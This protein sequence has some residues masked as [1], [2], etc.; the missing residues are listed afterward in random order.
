MSRGRRLTPLFEAMRET[1]PAKAS[2]APDS[3]PVEVPVP[4]PAPKSTPASPRVLNG[5]R[6]LRPV[7]DDDAADSSPST[8][9]ARESLAASVKQ[10]IERTYIVPGRMLL[11]GVSVLV[12]V[13]GLTWIIA[14]T[15]GERRQKAQLLQ[16]VAES[17]GAPPLQPAEDVDPRPQP[18]PAAPRT[19]PRA[20][21]T[22]SVQPITPESPSP[23]PDP[24]VNGNNYLYVVTTS[25]SDAQATA[26]FL[27]T[28]GL[29][30][31]MVPYGDKVDPDSERAKNGRWRVLVLEGI[32]SGQ[33]R[34]SARR[35]ELEADV[36]RIG[37]KKDRRGNTTFDFAWELYK[38]GT[39]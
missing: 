8:G 30:A 25:Y 33:F 5:P 6:V 31:G 16:R 26:A 3:P 27:T 36:R 37:W 22:P 14:Y 29:P 32:P 38:S 39:P 9:S 10:A 20:Q 34:N 21:N 15:A 35:S 28:N 4:A 18:P 1:T 13:L 23:G 2:V 11:I 19:E 24:R 7:A 12:V 17:S